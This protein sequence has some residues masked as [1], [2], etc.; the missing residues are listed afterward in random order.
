MLWT[1]KAKQKTKSGKKLHAKKPVRNKSRR[2]TKTQ[3]NR[4]MVN[5]TVPS[6][7]NPKIQACEEVE[8]GDIGGFG[9]TEELE[10]HENRCSQPATKLCTACGRNLCGTHYELLHWGHDSERRYENKEVLSRA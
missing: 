3:S 8:I 2:A 1:M 5:T 7:S 4:G 6:S 9:S 10:S